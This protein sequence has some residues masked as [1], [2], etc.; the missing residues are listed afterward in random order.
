M[1]ME[2]V[3]P[4]RPVSNKTLKTVVSWEPQLAVNYLNLARE[5]ALAQPSIFIQYFGTAAEGLVVGIE[6]YSV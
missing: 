2:F 4:K 6:R 5:S 1:Q 3:D